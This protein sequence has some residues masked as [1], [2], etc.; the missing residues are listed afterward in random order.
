MRNIIR[1]VLLRIPQEY[2]PVW[3]ENKFFTFDEVAS[4]AHYA[5]WLGRR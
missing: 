2:I 1:F 3:L 5:G 4:R